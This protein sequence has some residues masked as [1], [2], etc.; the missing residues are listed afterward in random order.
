MTKKKEI[1][2]PIIRVKNPEKSKKPQEGHTMSRAEAFKARISKSIIDL[3]VQGH[4]YRQIEVEL[5]YQVSFAE[6]G[7][8]VREWYG[9]IQTATAQTI[10]EAR[11]YE[12]ECLMADRVRLAKMIQLGHID[13]I[14]LDLA[15]LRRIT[16]LRGA[17][18]ASKIAATDF[19]G[20]PLAGESD[21]ELLAKAQKLLAGE[22]GIG[23][24]PSARA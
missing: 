14:E 2:K 18:V 1:R 23:F 20:R 10:E 11:Q 5:K 4:S 7:R 15:I 6:V 16:A 3:Y 13:S 21:E 12:I 19:N 8:I 9:E 24:K 17:D 22:N